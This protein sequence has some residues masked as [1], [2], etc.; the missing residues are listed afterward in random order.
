MRHFK[1]VQV[2]CMHALNTCTNIST[3]LP[4]DYSYAC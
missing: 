3:E 2:Q 1:Y 4:K